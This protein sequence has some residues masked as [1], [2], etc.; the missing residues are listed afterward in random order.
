MALNLFNIL[1]AVAIFIIFV[2][3]R[4]IIN[5]LRQKYSTVDRKIPNNVNLLGFYRI[6]IHTTPHRLNPNVILYCNAGVCHSF[7]KN[8][9]PIVQKRN[10]L[11]AGGKALLPTTQK[12]SRAQ[13]MRLNN[14]FDPSGNGSTPTSNL[15]TNTRS[16]KLSSNSSYV[17]A[18]E[19]EPKLTVFLS[20]KDDSVLNQF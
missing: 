18:V 16:S 13:T 15:S 5:T 3:K 12:C 7:E 11:H 2:C 9:S 19:D 1:Q 14:C 6:H 8:L 20:K 4:D 17:S 10:N